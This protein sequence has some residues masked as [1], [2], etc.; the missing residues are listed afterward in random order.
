MPARYAYRQSRIVALM[1]AVTAIFA[2]APAVLSAPRGIASSTPLEFSTE[3]LEVKFL[4][5]IN[6]TRVS[7]GLEVLPANQAIVDGSRLWADSMRVAEGISHDPN[8]KFAYSG[9]WVRLGEN[10]GT[11]PDVESIAAAF[12]ASP[13]HYAN[14]VRPGWDA[15]G[16][17][18]V[19]IGNRV[20]VVQRFL[21]EG[22]PRKLAGLSFASR[23]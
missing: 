21:D 16:I 10:V 2:L 23:G 14:I 20:Y 19:T 4:Q 6:E 8:L 7:V 15:A 18:V 12:V 11:G 1:I 5:H 9:T 22:P 17:G 13:S 3:Q